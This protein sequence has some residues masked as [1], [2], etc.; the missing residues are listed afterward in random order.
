MKDRKISIIFD[1]YHIY[2]LPQFD[3]VIDL[4]KNDPRF[5]VYLT[6]SQDIDKLE[7]D[8]AKSIIS[9]RG[10]KTIFCDLEQERMETIKAMNPD[11]FIC[12]W[13][14]YEIDKYVPATTKVGMIYHGIGVKPSYW[15]DNHSR[16]DI[17]FV[18]GQYRK[19]QLRNKGVTTDLEITGF[20]KID[21]LFH[22]DFPSREEILQQHQL[23]PNKKT[24]LYAPTFYPSSFEI[25]GKS[26]AEQTKDYNLIIKLHM[27]VHFKK[28][29]SDAN[30]VPQRK[31]LRKL[32]KRYQHIHVIEPEDYSIIP[33]Y[34]AADILV[35]D[36]SSTIYEMMA[37]D[38]PIIVC[39][40]YKLYLSHLLL[41]KRLYRKRLDRDMI[42]E[43][44]DF[45]VKIARPRDL[46]L[47]IEKVL[48]GYD[49]N[50]ELRNQL[51]EAML[52]KLDG[53]ASERIRDSIVMHMPQ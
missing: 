9:K 35:T 25:F 27:W 33:Y 37:L 50:P 24:I 52:Y 34:Q 22:P 5:E 15:R 49:P 4:L 18:E 16:L 23:D 13:S 8:L 47:A 20:S 32:Q 2:H 28:R 29:F 19:D 14:R 11:W 26:L 17:R 30:L 38:K 3:P 48:N 51:K 44:T 41:R 45:C 12:G 7:N 43:L 21:P 10:V 6:V 40:F 53:K 42:H 39:E 31:L 36:A 46:A 1:A